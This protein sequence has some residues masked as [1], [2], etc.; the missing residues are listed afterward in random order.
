M[1]RRV[2]HPVKGAVWVY[3]P[4]KAV[5]EYLRIMAAVFDGRKVTVTK[6]EK[7]RNGKSG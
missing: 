2:V 4:T 7:K 1:R 6:K 5:M 3:C